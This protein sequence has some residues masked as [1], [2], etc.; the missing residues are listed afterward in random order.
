[1]FARLSGITKPWQL[2]AGGKKLLA[3]RDKTLV[4]L[5]VFARVLLMP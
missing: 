3:K 4:V 1:M 5:S 2:W